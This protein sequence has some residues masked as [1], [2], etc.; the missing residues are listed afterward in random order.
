[1]SILERVKL[2]WPFGSKPVSV[3]EELTGLIETSIS[4]PDTEF[5]NRKA[6]Y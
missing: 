5:D 4:H 3:R 2:I 1:M 6:C